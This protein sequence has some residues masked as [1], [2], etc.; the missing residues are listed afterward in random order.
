MTKGIENLEHIE[1][2]GQIVGGEHGKILVRQKA[3]SSLELGDLLVVEEGQNST[4]LQVNNLLYGSQIEKTT[5][6]MM[7]GLRLEGLSGTGEFMEQELRSYVMAEV[8]ALVTTGPGGRAW[9]PKTLPPFFSEMRR[10]RKEDLSFLTRPETPIFLGVVR[11]GT[12][13]LDVPVYLN[14]QDVFTHHILIPATTGRGKSNLVKVMLWSVVGRDYCGILILDPHDEYF[15]RR[16]MGLKDHPKARDG[17]VYYSPDPPRGGQS[18]MVNLTLIKPHHLSGIV[19]MTD[20]Q[21]E[22]IWTFHRKYGDRWIENVMKEWSEEELERLHVHSGTIAVLQRRFK[23]VFDLKVSDGMIFS[24]NSVFVT[25]GGDA[26]VKDV[27]GHLEAGK[28]VIIDTSRLTDS[29]ELLI[30]SIVASEIFHHY[31]DR[32]GDPAFD[33]L[34]VISIVVEEAP[35]VLSG[36]EGAGTIY[37]QI[38]RE[39][40]KFKVGLTALT[41]LCSLIPRTVLANMN[42]KIIL[43]NEMAEERK[44]IIASASQD[45]SDDYKLIGALDKGEAIVSSVFTRFAIPIMAPLFEDIVEK[46]RGKAG[47]DKVAGPGGGGGDEMQAKKSK[48]FIG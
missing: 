23:M 20:A 42:T 25:D 41:Q 31:R 3:G 33:K 10:V 21:K 7:S 30:G 18:L 9:I 11:S 36:E 40:R 48:R 35:R 43:G 14:G 29:A 32:K 46:E 12:K 39:G 19:Q 45:L 6:E 8:K 38:A 24:R 4:I 26:F 28:K 16:G 47:L 5:L 34:P 13:H 2:V 1:V 37:G 15:G 27:V 17:I 22:A 44:A